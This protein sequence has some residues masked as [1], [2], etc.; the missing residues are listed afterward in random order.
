MST[1]ESQLQVDKNSEMSD[2][3]PHRPQATGN[4]HDSTLA[5]FPGGGSDRKR[6]KSM[7]GLLV[8]TLNKA[9]VEDKERNASEAAKKRQMLE[10][11]LQ[12]KL[13]KDADS[14]R[15]AEEA[16][17]EK[18]LANRKEEDLQLKDS[19]FKL[20]RKRLPL[21]TN[22]LNTAD[23]IP[24]EGSSPPPPSS[25]PLAPIAR[26]HPPPLYYLPAVLTTAQEEFLKRRKA[27]VSEAAEKEWEQFKEEREAGI[28]EISQLRQKVADEEARQKR[29]REAK[30]TS[31]DTDEPHHDSGETA[32]DT[33]ATAATEPP[34]SAPKIQ[35]EKDADHEMDVDDGSPPKPPVPAGGESERKEEPVPMQADDDDAVEY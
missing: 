23:I 28:A 13:R 27:E 21:L 16:K 31:M 5:P 9:K 7:F 26:T 8:G 19:I 2:C 34:S 25:N 35:G 29:E 20:R 32:K 22:F 15:R 4:D 6:G 24:P 1:E 17:K 33:G 10:Q 3:G 11:R 30:A 18:T 12:I 14:V